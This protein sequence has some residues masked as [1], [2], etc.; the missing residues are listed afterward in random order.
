[1]TD[2]YIVAV[3][4]GDQRIG[5]ALA[6]SVARLPRPFR[7]LQNVPTLLDDI[8]TA[9]SGETIVGLVVGLP[10]NMDGSLGAQAAKCQAFGQELGDVLGLEPVFTEE[11]LSSVEAEKYMDDLEARKAGLDAVAAACILER[12]FEEKQEDGDGVA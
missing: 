6:H 1:M 8:K 12:Y 2:G 7:T 10:R 11:T 5:L 4:Y 9:L 3:D